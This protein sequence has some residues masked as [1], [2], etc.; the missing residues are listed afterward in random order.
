[1]DYKDFDES[2]NKKR[3]KKRGKR[4]EYAEA[5]EGFW[6]KEDEPSRRAQMVT[7]ALS[8]LKEDQRSRHN[9]NLLHARLYGNFDML[10]F[11]ARQYARSGMALGTQVAFNVVASASDALIAKIAKHRP[12]PS[13]ITDGGVWKKQQQAKRLDRFTRGMFQEAKVYEKD[14]L[15][16][17]DNTVFGTG[18]YKVFISP[19]TG[20]VD[21]ERVFI[22]ELFVDEAEA[23]YGSP[24]QL[25]QVRLVHKEVLLQNYA[26]GA[27]AD[28]VRAAIEAAKAPPEVE[29]RGFGDMLEVVEVWH[30]R[31]GKK[32][33][34]GKHVIA[35][36]GCELLAEDW[37]MDR[38]P[39]V[40]CRFKP[41]VLGFWGEGVAE[42]LTGI[43]LELNRLVR[44]ISEQLRRKGRGRIMMPLAAKVPPEHITNG[45]AD[46]IYYN[47][48]IAPSVD[49]ANAVAAEE[50]QQIDRLYQKAFQIVG[51]SE[52][53][54]SAKK[55]SGLDAA[56]ALR[57]FED[58]ESERFAKQ[59]QRWDTFHMEL[60]EVMLETVRHFGGPDYVT[61]YERKTFTETI[62]WEDVKCEPG[63]YVIQMFPASSLPTV[64]GARRQ[65]VKELMSDGFIDKTVAQR[66]LDFPD[67]QTEAQLGS[68]AID[69]ADATI[70]AILYDD[71]PTYV[72]PDKYQ[73]LE[74]L[75]T[76]ALASYLFAKHRGCEEKRLAMLRRLI[77]ECTAKANGAAAGTPAAAPSQPPVGPPQGGPPPQMGD[78]NV[79]V[80]VPTPPTV[81]P[82]TA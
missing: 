3:G 68:A 15:V 77:D 22:D 82:L 20:K 21:V 78:Q 16:Y 2:A 41:R 62:R 31:S 81:P 73:N 10:G 27:K 65:A 30:L 33:K 42:M 28:E 60:A 54:V 11:G 43:Q 50:F 80:N 25:F 52:L 58:I 37:P 5:L 8:T 53:S 1:M 66:L 32:A 49:N 57:E 39:I 19:E 4:A 44:S 67:L 47:G 13:F 14:D 9:M 63:E 69:D 55:P 35:I 51:V 26:R 24:R 17:L 64:P 71:K 7:A 23:R 76:R 72:A 79:N 61:Q 45:I 56:V 34:D 36:D 70:D 18:G 59:H 6:W 29:R 48:N 38:F 75:A 40:L 46:I 74:L 12:R